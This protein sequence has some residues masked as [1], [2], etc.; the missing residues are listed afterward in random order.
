MRGRR[1]VAKPAPPKKPVWFLFGKILAARRINNLACCVD[2]ELNLS[3]ID[4]DKLS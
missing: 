4:L 1:V 2:T 3:L